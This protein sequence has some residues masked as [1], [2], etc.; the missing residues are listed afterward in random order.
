METTFLYLKDFCA[1]R[2]CYLWI[3]THQTAS[4]SGKNGFMLNI[5]AVSVTTLAT[6]SYGAAMFDLDGFYYTSTVTM[7]LNSAENLYITR[8]KKLNEYQVGVRQLLLVS[9]RY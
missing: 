4:V 6:I 8:L 3:I 7:G 1:C 9:L 5:I 2:S